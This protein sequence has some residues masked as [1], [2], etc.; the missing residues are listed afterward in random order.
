MKTQNNNQEELDTIQAFLNFQSGLV[1]LVKQFQTTALALVSTGLY[2]ENE[3]LIRLA[4][5]ADPIE[6]YDNILSNDFLV[7][8]WAIFLSYILIVKPTSVLPN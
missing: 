6:A 8:E 2:A 1:P 4:Q 3:D 7:R 5:I